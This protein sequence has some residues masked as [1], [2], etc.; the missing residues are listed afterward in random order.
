[1][2]DVFD[3]VYD[4]GPITVS[5]SPDE[6][7]GPAASGEDEENRSTVPPMRWGTDG[8]SPDEVGNGR[9]PSARKKRTT[10]ARHRRN[11]RETAPPFLDN[12]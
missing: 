6:E 9:A 3:A 12:M 1:M 10:E 11:A 4:R 7:N 8:R 2:T 5:S